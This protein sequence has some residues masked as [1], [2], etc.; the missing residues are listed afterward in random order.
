MTS[1]DNVLKAQNKIKNQKSIAEEIL[2]KLWNHRHEAI[3]AGGAPR[4]WDHGMP[5]NDLDIY[6][7]S[8]ISK[9]YL[10]E[11]FDN[12]T[13]KLG[14]DNDNYSYKNDTIES[15]YETEYKGI[16]VQI[17]ASSRTC[18]TVENL[19]TIMFKSF[20]FGLCKIA[21]T[22]KQ[23]T[24]EERIDY[25]LENGKKSNN[26]ELEFIR[27]SAYKKDKENKTLTVNME[28]MTIYN[29]PKKLGPRIEKMK[30]YFPEHN[31]IIE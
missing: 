29:D 11:I 31:L 14:K 22:K 30:S 12:K 1:L 28:Q 13:E 6:I 10:E 19:I 26:L 25:Y 24:I 18:Y 21:W 8:P 16:K 2:V 17:I 27:S 9:S 20:D 15:V 4:N 23:P 7:G 3:I 5:A